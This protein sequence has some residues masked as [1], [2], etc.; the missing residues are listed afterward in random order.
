MLGLEEWKEKNETNSETAE[1]SGEQWSNVSNPGN[2]DFL[3]QNTVENFH[4][5]CW[6]KLLILHS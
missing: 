6:K 4:R 3:V 5:E 2:V 1:I